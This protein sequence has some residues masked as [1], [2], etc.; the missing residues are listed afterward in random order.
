MQTQAAE[1]RLI[2]PPALVRVE[3]ARAVRE[4]Q[5]LRSLLRL[6]LRAAEDRRFIES[7]PGKLQTEART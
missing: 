4:T 7:L 1:H 2:P 5:Q 3:L 6:S